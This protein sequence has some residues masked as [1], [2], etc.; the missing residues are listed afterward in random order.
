MSCDLDEYEHIFNDAFATFEAAGIE[1]NEEQKDFVR[2][3]EYQGISTER[4][5]ALIRAINETA[6]TANSTAESFSHIRQI[7]DGKRNIK[8]I[9]LQ[10]QRRRKPRT[11]PR[12][13]RKKK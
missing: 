12:T 11:K 6:V 4:I 2:D 8:D 5:L 9:A 3:A 7:W 10:A 13:R 1:L